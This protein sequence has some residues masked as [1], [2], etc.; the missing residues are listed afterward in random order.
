[1]IEYLST[2]A[3]TFPTMTNKTKQGEHCLE[4]DIF[5]L[6]VGKLAWQGEVGESYELQIAEKRFYDDR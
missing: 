2:F 4:I 6:H 1:M 3:P 5:D